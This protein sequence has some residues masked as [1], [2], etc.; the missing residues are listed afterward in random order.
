MATHERGATLVEAALVLPIL[1]FLLFAIIEVGG[2]LKSYSGVASAVRLGG[3]SASLAGS[4]PLA[5]GM[6]LEQVARQ[7][8]TIDAGEIEVVVIWHAAGPGDPV[9]PDCLPA[10]TTVP[11]TSSVGDDGA[12][13][14]V[15]ACNVYIQPDAAGGAF[16]MAQGTAAEAEDHYFGCSGASDPDAAHKLDCHWPGATRQVLTSPRESLTPTST[17]FVGVY[18]RARHAYYTGALGATVTITDQSI[19]QLEPQGYTLS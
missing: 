11:N 17:D 4:D 7:A 5:D 6:I 18:I 12:A 16:A 3:R 9:P 2:S 19:T 10:T 1:F 13:D 15:G 14:G 8:S